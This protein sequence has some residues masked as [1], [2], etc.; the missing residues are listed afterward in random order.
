MTHIWQYQTLGAPRFYLR[1]GRELAARRLNRLAMYAYEQGDPF[2][3][4]MLEAQADMVR[5]YARN[6]AGKAKAGPSLADTG[7]YG[8]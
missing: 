3:K 1:Y 2:D 7:L 5:D 4:A 6:A 8:L